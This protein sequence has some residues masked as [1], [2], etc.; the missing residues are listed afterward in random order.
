MFD[1]NI[2][3][4]VLTLASHTH[5]R[6]HTH[7][8]FSLFFRHESVRNSLSIGITAEILRNEPNGRCIALCGLFFGDEPELFVFDRSF[9]LP[10]LF[11]E[12]VYWQCYL[13]QEIP[14][15]VVHRG[16]EGGGR[17]GG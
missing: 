13:Y 10:I 7:I 4:K 9:I 8:S 15:A 5:T 16:W 14:V 12:N 1:E 17:D 6:T 2:F 3:Y 11:R